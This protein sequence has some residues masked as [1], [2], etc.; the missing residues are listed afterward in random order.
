MLSA[1]LL[2]PHPS[3]YLPPLCRCGHPESAH[4][5]ACVAG[6]VNILDLASEAV[7]AAA[8]HG[9]DPAEL[10]VRVIRARGPRCDCRGFESPDAE[11]F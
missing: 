4:R 2:E 1:A 6:R 11:A 3:A 9:L 7:E 8:R 10:V 5:E